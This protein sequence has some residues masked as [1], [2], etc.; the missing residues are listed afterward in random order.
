MT[1]R[2]HAA[3]P[4]EQARQDALAAVS[5]ATTRDQLYAAF[6]RGCGRL[7]GYGYAGACGADDLCNAIRQLD[8]ARAARCHALWADDGRQPWASGIDAELAAQ[9]PHV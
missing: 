4:F 6:E 1:A 7:E 8:A 5:R 3:Y 9:V 2:T